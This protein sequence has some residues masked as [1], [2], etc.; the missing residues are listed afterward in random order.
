MQQCEL[1]NDR[2]ALNVNLVLRIDCLTDCLLEFHS[3]KLDY[4]QDE[5]EL[6]YLVKQEILTDDPNT[7]TLMLDMLGYAGPPE[8]DN[9]QSYTR[10]G[11]LLETPSLISV[12]SRLKAM[13]GIVSEL[14]ININDELTNEYP[15]WGIHNTID[16]LY[17]LSDYQHVFVGVIPQ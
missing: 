17:I 15:G 16:K 1:I 10:K 11:E 5:G 2:T 14:A 7:T 3:L 12:E 13:E 4:P 8:E 6:M 9:E